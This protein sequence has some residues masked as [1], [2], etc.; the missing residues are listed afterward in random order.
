MD[1]SRE[2]EHFI[3]LERAVWQAL[4][5]GDAATDARL[6]SDEFLGVYATGIASKSD[7]VGQLQRGPSV[8]WYD[9]SR[10]QMMILAERVVALS[11]FARWARAPI[12]DTTEPESMYVTSIWRLEQGVWKN[13]FSQ[14][15]HSRD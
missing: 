6:L 7:H 9:L 10:P 13:V 15:T 2:I 12:S 3:E 1:A 11:Y 8:A 5:D 14:D 4:K